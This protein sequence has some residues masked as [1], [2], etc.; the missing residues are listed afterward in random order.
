MFV[1][2]WYTFRY[3]YLK[4]HTRCFMVLH[5]STNEDVIIESSLRAYTRVLEIKCRVEGRLDRQEETL[6]RLDGFGNWD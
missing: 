2:Y 6:I 3:T 1:Y 5:R 4:D